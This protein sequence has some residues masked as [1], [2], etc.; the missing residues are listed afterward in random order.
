[1]IITLCTQYIYILTF[2]T[3]Y[4][5]H[6]PFVLHPC[7]VL[8]RPLSMSSKSY[9]WVHHL[10]HH[11]CYLCLI[12]SAPKS[13][14]KKPRPRNLTDVEALA[15]TIKNLQVEFVLVV[16]QTWLNHL[17]CIVWVLAQCVIL[18]HTVFLNNHFYS[19]YLPSIAQK[20]MR[21]LRT[22]VVM[23]CKC[24]SISVQS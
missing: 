18:Y 6:P 4:R 14:I 16:R 7:P 19:A 1:M 9:L 8:A 10:I 12:S 13:T 3:G 5:T 2:Q 24:Q 17:F 22:T 15:L 20:A 11:P 21:P 23:R